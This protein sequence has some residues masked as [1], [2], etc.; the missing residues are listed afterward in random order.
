MKNDRAS[1]SDVRNAY[2]DVLLYARVMLASFRLGIDGTMMMKKFT[3]RVWR[4]SSLDL[5]NRST[6]SR[7]LAS[8][9]V[10]L[11]LSADS[12][13]TLLPPGAVGRERTPRRDKSNMDDF[14]RTTTVRCLY[15][16]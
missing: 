5:L 9:I 4:H 16:N 6:R 10:A 13:M 15:L 7:S 14:Q 1:H 3:S 11:L 8:S 2:L 12:L